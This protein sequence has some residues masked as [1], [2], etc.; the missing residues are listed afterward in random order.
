MRLPDAGLAAGP[1]WYHGD[2]FAENLL[3]RDGRLTAVLDFGGLGI[4]D[5]TI[6]L[7][8]A[9]EVLDGAAR[10]VFRQELGVD[11]AS[12]LR[13]RA[14]ALSLA[15]ITLP[16]YWRTMP[17]RCAGKLAVAKAVLAD[18]SH[19]GGTGPWRY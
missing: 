10:D 12:W 16:Y 17:D 18:A 2:L 4:G 5:P 14:W 6:D 7:I 19:D 3:V 11:E 13:A 1:H 8:V 9:W 15:M